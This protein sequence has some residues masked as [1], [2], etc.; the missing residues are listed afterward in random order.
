MPTPESH[1]GEAHGQVMTRLAQVE[2]QQEDL[3][4]ELREHARAN[5][6]GH[7]SRTEFARLEAQV[8]EMRGL[9]LKLVVGVLVAASGGSALAPA[10]ARVVAGYCG[11]PGQ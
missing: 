3:Q 4:G 8:L 5:G 10:V 7:V 9:L 1:C 11:L 6:G 2:R